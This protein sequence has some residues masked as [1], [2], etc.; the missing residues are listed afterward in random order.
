MFPGILRKASFLAA[1]GLVEYALQLVLPVILVRYLTK[2]EF[3]DYRLIWLVAAT[4]L[5]LFPLCMPQSLFYF[6]PRAAAGN[7]PK[8]VGNVFVSL[9][10]LGGLAALLL[11]VLIP[12]L[13]KSIADLQRYSPF[14]EIFVGLWI[15]GSILQNLPTADG[16]AEWQAYAMIVFA[17]LRTS[18]L[19]VLAVVSGDLESILVIMCGLATLKIGMA[20]L[21]ALFAAQEP[22]LGFDNQLLRVQIRYSLPFAIAEGLFALRL[23]ADQWVVAANFPSTA[24]ALVSIASV[25]TVIGMLVRQPLNYA[26]VPNI[27][28][29]VFQGNLD[30]AISLISKG[31]LLLGLALPPVLG[32]LILTADDLVEL[33]YTAEYLGA[34]PLM[35]I[36]LLGQ[37]ATV[38]AAGH[39]LLTFGYGKQAATTGAIALLLSL[40]ASILGVKLFGLAGA[41]A[42]STIGLV[43]WEWWALHKVA[44]GLGTSAFGLMRL[45]DTWKVWLVVAIGLAV[46]YVACSWL[47]LSIVSRLVVKS[48]IFVIAVLLGLA[49]T[50]FRQSII[51]L[52]ISFFRAPGASAAAQS[53]GGR[54]GKV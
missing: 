13:P 25:V 51:S 49:L 34:V 22:G 14:V 37:I 9:L 38:F 31:Y 43:V 5:I 18:A 33:I 21:Y 35:R 40:G 15:V 50:N 36:Y 48:L 42:G 45:N 32:F 53:L 8:L 16:K 17:I 20:V 52:L 54:A 10:V 26:L 6:L 41:V 39:L 47:D 30:G 12:A 3:G 11:V 24:F 19:A 27:G 2:S 23:Q 1:A 44:K 7:R 28:S 46:A 29:L 4:A